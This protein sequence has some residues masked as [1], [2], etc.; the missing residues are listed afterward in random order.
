MMGMCMKSSASPSQRAKPLIISIVF[1]LLLLGA[2]PSSSAELSQS[3]TTLYLTCLNEASCLLDNS[4]T[5]V[6]TVSR[7]ESDATPASP[8]TVTLEFVMNPEQTSLALIPLQIEELTVD[9]V[10]SD[11]VGGIS[12]PDLVVDLWIGSS[13]NS[14]TIAGGSPGSPKDGAYT[15]EEANLDLSRGRMLRPG[16]E[17]GLSIAFEVDRPTTWELRLRGDSRLIVPIEWSADIAAKNIDEPSSAGN[18]VI[19]DDFEDESRGALLDADQDCYRFTLPEHVRS[20]TFVV[21]WE[22]A[23][24][25]VMQPQTP[26]ELIREGGKTPK[27]PAVKTTFEASEIVSEIRYE[28]PLEGNYLACWTGKMDRFQAYSW[29]GRISFQGM[30][31]SSPTEFSGD[32]NWLAGQ[33]HVGDIEDS[34]GVSGSNAMMLM[35][36]LVSTTAGFAGFA[37]PTNFVWSKRLLLPLALIM[38][39]LGGIASP[40]FGLTDEAARPGEMTL[41]ELIQHRLEVIAEAGTDDA[42]STSG[43]FG[44]TDGEKM[45]LRLHVTGSHPIGDGR[46]QI[47]VEELEE[48]RLDDYVFSYVSSNPIASGDEVTFILHAGR[49]LALDL[50]ML[51]AL[52][53]VDDAPE[54]SLMHIDWKMEATSAAG[55]ATGPVWSTRP[56]S[57]SEADWKGLQDDLFPELLTISYCDC[58]MDGMEI[59]WRPSSKLDSNSLATPDGMSVAGGFLSNESLWVGTGIALILLAGGIEYKRVKDAEKL[60]KDFF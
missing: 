8:K 19:L 47:Q 52:L 28:D 11:D 60:A 20:A 22:S 23:P 43:F 36:G 4:E 7:Q 39:I 57:V 29:F 35:I 31:S 34:R 53:V 24:L 45:S 5:G 14:W 16:D 26:P 37:V 49:A 17:V 1:L 27:N 18:P 21:H 25:E 10:F 51:E 9:L 56:T 15:I 30:G 50:L 42:A 58:G 3:D 6:E 41:D 13:S 38:L 46:W 54:G 32:A 12:S 40:V 48:V 2:V 59:S 55:S 33:A 44:L